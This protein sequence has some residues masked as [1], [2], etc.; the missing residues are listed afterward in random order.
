MPDVTIESSRKKKKRERERERERERGKEKR[1]KEDGKNEKRHGWP[2]VPDTTYYNAP[3]RVRVHRERGYREFYERFYCRDQGRSFLM[4][5]VAEGW[6]RRFSSFPTKRERF[7]VP[8]T[9]R[10]LRESRYKVTSNGMDS[11]VAFAIL[12]SPFPSAGGDA[13]FNSARRAPPRSVLRPLLQTARQ[14]NW[15]NNARAAAGAA[16]REI[17][18]STAFRKEAINSLIRK[19]AARSSPRRLERRI[20]ALSVSPLEISIVPPPPPPPPPRR[21]IKRRDV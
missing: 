7:T 18:A 6:G 9:P 16:R 14:F 17:E 20:H 4:D 21:I 19:A 5:R 10:P 12:P 2:R 15:N 13:T 1:K 11:R 8:A 3:R